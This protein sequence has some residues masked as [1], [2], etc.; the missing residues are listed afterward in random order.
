MNGR[1]YLIVTLQMRLIIDSVFQDI[2]SEVKKLRPDMVEK[3]GEIDEPKHLKLDLNVFPCY[4]SILN[5]ITESC[6]SLP[7]V[8]IL[9]KKNLYI[10]SD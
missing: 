1:H 6:F 5:K 2:Y 3:A 10:H 8:R 9:L 7:R 4:R